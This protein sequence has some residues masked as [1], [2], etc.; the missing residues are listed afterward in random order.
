M[1]ALRI[2]L[3][4]VLLEF[5]AFQLSG[6]GFHS[7]YKAPFYNFGVDIF[8]VVFYFFHIPQTIVHH[9]WLGYLLDILIVVLLL[10]QILLPRLRYLP[11]LLLLL[12]FTYYVTLAG[13]HTHSNY[14]TGF[15]LILIPFIFYKENNRNLAFECLR[16]Y[17]LFFYFSAAYHKLIT[18]SLWEVNHFSNIIKGQFVPYFIEDHTSIRTQLNFYLAQHPFGSYL[19]YLFGTLLEFIIIIGFFTKKY[20]KALGII[21]LLFHFVNWFVMDIGPF[22]QI[23][24]VSM[25]FFS[26]NFQFPPANPRVITHL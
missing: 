9:L 4:L 17:L 20:D 18:G 19:F 16:Y 3:V 25:L 13:Y 2:L 11:I 22:G 5:I 26:Q 24:F 6:V 14:Q 8:F 15:V 1:K 10:V 12:L 23:A 21:I 7:L